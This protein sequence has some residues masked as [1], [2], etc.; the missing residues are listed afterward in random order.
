MKV[1]ALTIPL[2]ASH[3]FGGL[4]EIKEKKSGT[5]VS[6]YRDACNQAGFGG[7]W[8]DPSLFVHAQNAVRETQEATDEGV[9]KTARDARKAAFK[10]AK[11]EINSDRKLTADELKVILK[12]IIDVVD[13]GP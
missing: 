11:N 7:P 13:A 4:C 2:F 10:A 12:Q 5:V 8:G 9:A 3:A 1:L 6:V